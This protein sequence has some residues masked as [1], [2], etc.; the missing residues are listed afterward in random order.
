LPAA[1]LHDTLEVDLYFGG[2]VAASS[3]PR[4]AAFSTGVGVGS[5]ICF[6]SLFLKSVFWR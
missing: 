2:L 4:I 1:I 6:G 3:M 5:A